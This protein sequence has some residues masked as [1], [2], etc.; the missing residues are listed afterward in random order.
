MKLELTNK[1]MR[2]KAYGQLTRELCELEKG[3]KFCGHDMEHFLAVARVA[4][5]MCFEKGIEV[6]A[7]IIYS[8]ALL[9]DLGRIEEYTR[10]EPHDIAGVRTAQRLLDEIGCSPD[11]RRQILS[12]I[13]SHRHS[14]ENDENSPEYIFYLAD[15]RSR[16]CFACAASEECNWKPEKRNNEIRE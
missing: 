9:H 11:E 5:I 15:K 2:N 13:S 3:R 7:D 12:L 14:G 8:A 6:N 1:I 10:G 16:Q 4:L